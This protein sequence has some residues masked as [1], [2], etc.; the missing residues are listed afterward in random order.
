MKITFFKMSALV[1]TS[2]LAS[3]GHASQQE[4]QEEKSVSSPFLKRA[5]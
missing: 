5:R 3:G 2:F 1:M 4:L